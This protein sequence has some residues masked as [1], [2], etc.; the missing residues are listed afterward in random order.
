MHA[1]IQVDSKEDSNIYQVKNESIVL[2]SKFL[3]F[4]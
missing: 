4:E 3:D 2:H 1:V